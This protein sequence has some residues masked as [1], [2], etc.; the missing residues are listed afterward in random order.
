MPTPD[1][2]LIH[3]SIATL[4]WM[5]ALDNVKLALKCRKVDADEATQISLKMLELL[6]TDI[7][8]NCENPYS[9]KYMTLNLLAD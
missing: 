4:P 2:A 3:Q 6:E 1:I 9:F 5:T 8:Y 7:S